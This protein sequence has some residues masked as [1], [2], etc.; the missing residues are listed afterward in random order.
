MKHI[1][2]TATLSALIF[3]ALSIPMASAAGNIENGKNLYQRG[4][5]A[6]HDTSVHSRPDRIVHSFGSLVN[7]VRACD[8]Q[9]STGFT[10]QQISDITEYLN[11]EFY[12]FKK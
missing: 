4:C 5:T 11:A 1:K 2:L 6:C 8:A 9:V 3:A 12:K 7:R 10:D